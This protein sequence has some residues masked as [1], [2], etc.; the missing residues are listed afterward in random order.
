MRLW[1]F[2]GVVGVAPS[3]LIASARPQHGCGTCL[4]VKCIDPTPKVR[5]RTGAAKSTPAQRSQQP[6][7]RLRTR[8]PS[9][10]ACRVPFTPGGSTGPATNDDASGGAVLRVMVVDTCP[11]CA[12]NTLNL[13]A[14]GFEEIARTR[15]G[16][17]QVAFK[18]VTRGT[19]PASCP[20][21]H[22]T[23]FDWQSTTLQQAGGRA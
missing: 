21:R 10:Q 2:H 4:A 17:V 23:C 1:P 6:H 7:S 3:S 19:L 22:L 11:S 9:S 12:A 14:F 20:T 15:F 13:H 18:Q 16:S 8:T 5:A